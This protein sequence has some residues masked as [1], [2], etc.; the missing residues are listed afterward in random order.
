[1]NDGAHC[2]YK[3]LILAFFFSTGGKEQAQLLQEFLQNEGGSKLR[4]GRKPNADAEE[5]KFFRPKDVANRRKYVLLLP[6][7]PLPPPPTF[8]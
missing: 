7:L 1:M 3:L 4:G 2:L 6:L 8:S 5:R